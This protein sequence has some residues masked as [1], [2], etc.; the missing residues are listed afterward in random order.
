VETLD[1]TGKKKI[2]TMDVRRESFFKVLD[3]YHGY[4]TGEKMELDELKELAIVADRFPI[5]DETLKANLSIVM[6][7]EMLSWVSMYGLIQSNEA[8]RRLATERF[9]ELAKTEAFM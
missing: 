8:A 5:L 1:K 7:G 9:E 6:C 4:E 2:K 3:I